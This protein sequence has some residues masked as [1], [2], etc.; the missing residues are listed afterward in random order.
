LKAGFGENSILGQE[1]A[2]FAWRIRIGG[3]L[4]LSLE[5]KIGYSTAQK[6]QVLT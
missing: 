6:A 1:V 3:D 4:S 2:N 5:C